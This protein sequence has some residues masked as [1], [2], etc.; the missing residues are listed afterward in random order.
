MSSE[1]KNIL[2]VHNYY[3]IPGGEDTVVANEKKML[4]KHGHKVILYSR[5]NAELKQMSKIRIRNV[6]ALYPSAILI[7][8]VWVVISEVLILILSKSN[9]GRKIFL[10][11][12]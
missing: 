8:I 12:G 5:N 9:A 3:Q 10:G 4:E 11:V 6:L 7:S 2:I 1:K